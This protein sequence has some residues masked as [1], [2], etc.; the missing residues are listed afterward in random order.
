MEQRKGFPNEV[1][2]GGYVTWIGTRKTFES[3]AETISFSLAFGK[4]NR[5]TRVTVK[6]WGDVVPQVEALGISDKVEVRG[7]LSSWEQVTEGKKRYVLE[8]VADSIEVLGKAEATHEHTA[9]F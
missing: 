9:A 7:R 4:E 1:H 8:V 6:A 3:G 5:R 2:T